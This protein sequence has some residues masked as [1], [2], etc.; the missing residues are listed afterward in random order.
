[1]TDNPF[2][3]VRK[4]NHEIVGLPHR[5][6]PYEL[7]ADEQE[8]LQTVFIEEANEFEQAWLADDLIGQVDALIDLIYFAMGGLTR[9][10][11]EPDKSLNIFNLQILLPPPSLIH[12]PFNRLQISNTPH[13]TQSP[14]SQTHNWF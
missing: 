3:L 4:F 1:M 13:N 7:N 2:E 10:G 8:W 11:V 14:F 9:L 5:R 12:P 6:F